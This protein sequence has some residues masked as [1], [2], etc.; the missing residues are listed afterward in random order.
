VAAFGWW[1]S[2]EPGTPDRHPVADCAGFSGTIYY[3]QYDDENSRLWQKRPDGRG[4]KPLPLGVAGEPS[5]HVHAGHRWFLTV[6]EVDDR[7]TP[8]GRPGRELFAVRDDGLDV[9]LTTTSE[10]D[11]APLTPRWPAHEADQAISWIGRRWSPSGQVVEGGIYTARLT[12]DADGRVVGL[13]GPPAGP[14]VSPDLVERPS[15][16]T[17]HDALV[18]DIESHDWS[19]DGKAVVYDSTD[20]QLHVTVLAD[21]KVDRLTTTPGRDPVWSPDGTSI[22]FKVAEPLGGIVLVNASGA[23]PRTLMRCTDGRPFVVAQPLWSPD[24]KHMAFVQVGSADEQDAGAPCPFDVFLA[25]ADGSRV[26]NV[27]QDN[28]DRLWPVAWR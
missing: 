6:R 9:R 18:P 17:W 4:M 7:P 1:K 26:V 12:F 28:D 15:G 14:L 19:H 25:D 2:G 20:A 23:N 27:T 22:A 10:L 11:P 5:R 16:D 8:D 24:G 3:R 13:S 21:G